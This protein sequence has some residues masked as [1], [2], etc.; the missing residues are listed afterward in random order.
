[1]TAS[2]HQY[3][4]RGSSDIHVED[5]LLRRAALD[6]AESERQV[7]AAVAEA[8]RRGVTWAEIAQILGIPSV[9]AQMRY[10]GIR[11]AS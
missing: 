9:T 7:A 6:R 8:L 2:K 5:Y 10:G 4:T 3:K 1:M 11:R